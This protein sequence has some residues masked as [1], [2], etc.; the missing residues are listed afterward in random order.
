VET[1][2]VAGFPRV[3]TVPL[4]CASSRALMFRAYVSR[5]TADSACLTRTGLSWC[6]ARDACGK[7]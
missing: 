2:M 1:A 4:P 6:P 7:A 5:E 3:I